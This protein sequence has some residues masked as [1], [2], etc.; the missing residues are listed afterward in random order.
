MSGDDLWAERFY[1]VASLRIVSDARA[2]VARARML[3]ESDFGG[4]FGWYVV[5]EDQI[6]GALHEPR[7]EDMFWYSYR[8]APGDEAHRAVLFDTTL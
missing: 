1:W 6:V 8:V 3:A 5:F 7:F 4:D 2:E